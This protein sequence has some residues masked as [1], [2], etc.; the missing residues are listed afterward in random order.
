MKFQ[1]SGHWMAIG[2][3]AALLLGGCSGAGSLFGS[4]AA[5]SA[6]DAAS[7]ASTIADAVEWITGPSDSF[8]RKEAG[9]SATT[10]DGSGLIPVY[11]VTKGDCAQGDTALKEY[12]YNE[13]VAENEAKTWEKLHTAA[14]AEAQK[15]TYCRT[16]IKGIVY[17]SSSGACQDGEAVISEEEYDAAKREAAVAATKLP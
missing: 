5:D 9:G 7:N 14:Q 16:Q 3:I 13:I 8:C 15:P 17:R 11:K 6:G 1:R 10:T 2:A 4:K 12:E